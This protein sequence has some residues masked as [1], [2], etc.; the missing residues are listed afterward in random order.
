MTFYH[1]TPATNLTYIKKEGLH[2]FGIGWF[3]TSEEPEPTVSISSAVTKV[4]QGRIAL[5]RKILPKFS[6]ALAEPGGFELFSCFMDVPIMLDMFDTSE[7]YCTEDEIKPQDIATYEV[8][9]EDGTW[10]EILKE[11]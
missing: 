10:K 5:K 9:Q 3:T 6:I 2:H 8:Q 11:K 1:Y 7:W 4:P